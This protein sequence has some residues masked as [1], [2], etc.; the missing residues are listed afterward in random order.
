MLRMVSYDNAVYL[1]W[2]AVE[3][4]LMSS[5]DIS[6]A[7]ARILELINSKENEHDGGLDQR[8]KPPVR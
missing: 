7:H 1:D 5:E 2:L 4:I 6:Q 3:H 8:I